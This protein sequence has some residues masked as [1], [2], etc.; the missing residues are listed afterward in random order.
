MVQGL[1]LNESECPKL[2]VL[3][4]ADKRLW[5]WPKRWFGSIMRLHFLC[6]YGHM[7]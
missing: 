1:I 4:P 7:S 3:L 6:S 5:Q 2:F